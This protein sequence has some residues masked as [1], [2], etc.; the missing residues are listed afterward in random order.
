MQALPRT[1]LVT[2]AT[3]SIG[4]AV[5]DKLAKG[6]ASLL[7]AARNVNEPRSLCTQLPAGGSGG[8]H[9]WIGV[10]MA[11]DESI[12]EFA[13]ELAARNVILDGAVLMPPQDPPT[14]DPLPS[15][16]K[17]REVLQNSF[18]GPLALLKV[19]I[20][21][22]K[23]DP[24]NGRRCKIVIVSGISS[25]QVLGNYASSNVDSLRLAGRSQDAGARVRRTRY[26]REYA[27][28]RRHAHARLRCIPRQACC[29][30]GHVLQGAPGRR[31]VQRAPSQVRHTR[32]G[33]QRGRRIVVDVLR[34]HDRTQRASRWW[35][36]PR[37]WTHLSDFSAPRHR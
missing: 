15:S 28:A 22:M 17:W 21:A 20:G 14:S 24:A 35:V 2:G 10:D 34:S 18:V 36:H 26:S 3:G 23:P 19:A 9:Q 4:L 16:A 7:L 5:S 1:I 12:Q 37:V 30:R 27:I 33:G 6:G 29:Q 8:H 25:A 32:G 31:N 13:D 11:L